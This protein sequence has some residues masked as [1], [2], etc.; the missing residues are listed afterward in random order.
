MSYRDPFMM[1]EDIGTEEDDVIV[2][3][4]GNDTITG[5]GGDD[6]LMGLTG[7]DVINGGDG[8]DV[9]DGG[10][11][12]DAMIGGAGD[13]VMI[14]TEGDDDVNGGSGSDHYVINGTAG[15]DVLITDTSG[16][17]DVLDARG[18]ITSA[19]IDM[20]A[21]ESSYVDGRRI[22]LAGGEEVISPLDLYMLQD[23]SGSFGDDITTV[24]GLLPA[25]VAGVQALAPDVHFGVGSFIDKPGR[26]FGVDTDHE[27]REDLALTPDEAALQA[28]YDGLT[29][30]NGV[31]GPESQLTA[32]L[33]TG[34]RADSIG[35]REEAIR[36]AVLF[37]DA[38]FHVA[39][40]NPDDGPNDGDEVLDGTPPGLGEDYPEI[41]QVAEALNAEGINVIFAVAG[42]SSVRDA[43]EG[44]VAELGF[45]EVVS[46]SDDSS[47]LT[48]KVTRGVSR[49]T[50]TEIEGAIGGDFDD[51]IVGNALDNKIKGRDGDDVI[52]G[53]DGNDSIIGGRGNDEIDGQEGDDVIEGN[54][55]DDLINGG[56]GSDDIDGGEDNDD[57]RGAN[58]NDVLKGGEGDDTIRG[59]NGK[60]TIEGGAGDDLLDGQ[61]KSDC[62]VFLGDWGN[63]TIDGYSPS[64]A[65]GADDQVLI[66]GVS[67][68]RD[69]LSGAT[70]VREDVVYTDGD[71]TI[72][73]LDTEL[74]DFTDNDFKTLEEPIVIIDD[75]TSIV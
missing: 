35:F 1:R 15:D 53:A 14:A 28:T 10:V 25:F 54:A 47:D 13:D 24:R 71:R 9:V 62:F 42:G 75:F 32:L 67:N 29:V 38:A 4:L 70:Q 57:I 26:G 5:E 17:C 64:E 22:T 59:G 74:D 18:A 69:F 73:F 60:D 20:N 2:G 33:Q 49:L 50:T 37:T 55:G 68:L 7:R 12:D 11:G 43:Y 31:D 16:E 51:T 44:L 52:S 39:G 23:L 19:L 3:S 27:F 72:T 65:R 8:D 56:D 41:I 45:G 36:V 40:D 48:A 66:E 63:D 34:V 6:V 30:G 61:G 58:G 46:L 21:G